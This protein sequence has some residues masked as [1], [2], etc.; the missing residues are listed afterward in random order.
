MPRQKFL[1][2]AQAA[3]LQTLLNSKGD[4]TITSNKFESVTVLEKQIWKMSL[5][6]NTKYS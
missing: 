6:S 1:S 5:Q 4:L 3:E 2:I